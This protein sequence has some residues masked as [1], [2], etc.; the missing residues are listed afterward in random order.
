MQTASEKYMD[1]IEDF[2]VNQKRGHCQYFAA[3]LT[4]T[5][6]HLGVPTRIVLGYHPLEYNEI[7]TTSRF[8]G[9]T[10]TPG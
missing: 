8:G 6:R 7:A 3:A 4:M 1:P 10:P 9:A 5:L 2:I